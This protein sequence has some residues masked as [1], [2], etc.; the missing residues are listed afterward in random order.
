MTTVDCW[1][2][3]GMARGIAD[4]ADNASARAF[5]GPQRSHRS[6]DA[7]SRRERSRSQIDW[8]TMHR[9]DEISAELETLQLSKRSAIDDILPCLRGL[10]ETENVIVYSVAERLQG[11]SLDR[12]HHDGQADLMQ[13]Q[14]VRVFKDA[15]HD[16][17]PYSPL[18]PNPEGRNRPVEAISWL[19]RVAPG[20]FEASAMYKAVFAPLRLHHH[21]QLRVLLCDGPTL[22]AW[23]GMIHDGRVTRRHYHLIS[24]V[25]PAMQRRLKVERQL[26]AGA[27]HSPDVGVLLD[28]IGAPAL[29]LG[30]QNVIREANE[31]GRALLAQRRKDVLRAIEGT[32]AGP[33]NELHAELTPVSVPG[34]PTSWLVIFRASSDARSE[35]CVAAAARRWRL[36]PRQQQVLAGVVQ[37]HSTATL[38]ALLAVSPRAVELHITRLFDQAGVNGRAALVAHVLCLK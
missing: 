20:T 31:S 38:A 37:G 14:L 33:S 1:Y 30:P 15:S 10:L 11:W 25:I 32:V 8:Q 24:S 21:K 23:F 28:H 4:G 18:C 16:M 12:W 3:G 27:G 5:H 35:Q 2:S 22:L 7:L 34:L 36:T 19:N 17:F 6:S 9:L 26:A 13:E 29:L